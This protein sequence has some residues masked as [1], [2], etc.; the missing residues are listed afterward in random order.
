[1]TEDALQSALFHVRRE[2]TRSEKQHGEWKHGVDR[3]IVIATEELGEAAAEAL[4]ATRATATEA[5]RVEARFRLVSELAQLAGVAI[6][7]IAKLEGLQ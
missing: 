4:A 6:H 3:G 5:Q 7:M 1:M 2:L